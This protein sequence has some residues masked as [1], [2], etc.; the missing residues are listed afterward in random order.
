M[1][2]KNIIEKKNKIFIAGHNGMVGKS[3]K[4][5]FLKNG[6][7]NLIYEDRSKLDLTNLSEVI[8]FFEIYRPEI[9]V[10]AAAKVGGIVAN[11]NYPT[12]FILENLKIQ[13][14]IIETS[15]KYNV[16]RF[17]FLGSSCIYPKFS[18]QPIKEEYLLEG[19]LE[20]T[21]EY[22][23]I[24][25]IAGIKLC[26]ALR[27]QYKFDA[28]CLMPTNL[29]GPGDNYDYKNSHVLPA[30]IRKFYEAKIKKLDI[31]SCWGDGS[32]LREFLHAQDL[33]EACLFALENYCPS[34]NK[35]DL[36]L[37]HLNVGT[38]KDITIKELAE[39]VASLVGFKGKIV[40]DTSKPNGTHQK[41]LDISAIRKLGW[42][43][44]I[45]LKQGIDRTIKEYIMD[46]KNKNEHLI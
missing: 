35:N 16:K 34:I 6:Y 37:I 21:N 44:K 3:I 40:W 46:I 43:P 26:Q 39:L 20:P 11:S 4:E 36:D 5:T 7:E 32:P 2:K 31:V 28:I 17:L 9:V 8:A 27:K 14:N 23:A 38:G 12:E 42:E 15:W 25:K 18:K 45:G 24:A 10:L 30:L 1:V 29:Y 22:Y 19:N 41:K 13:T 33:G